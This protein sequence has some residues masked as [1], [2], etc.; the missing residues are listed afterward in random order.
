M[1]EKCVS[2][3]LNETPFL[4]LSL[5][6]DTVRGGDIF[7]FTILSLALGLPITLLILASI[8]ILM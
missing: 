3:H 2:R 4:P 6:S 8:V 5:F 1:L 7:L